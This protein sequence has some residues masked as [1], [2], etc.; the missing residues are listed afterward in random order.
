[1]QTLS[2]TPGRALLE[3]S[4]T[5]R[6][7][8][9]RFEDEGIAAYLYVCDRALGHGDASILD[10]M[11]IYNV[12]ALRQAAQS[13]RSQLSD[14]QLS[15]LQLGDSQSSDSQLSESQLTK[16]QPSNAEPSAAQI[17]APPTTSSA[18]SAAQTNTSEPS[19][20]ER[21]AA[22][23]WSRDGLQAVFYLDGT[24]QAM[25]DFTRRISFC[26]SDFPNFLAEGTE[27][28]RSSTHAWDPAA[29]EHFEA[30]LYA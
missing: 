24:A 23:E 9:L 29:V 5:N 16:S 20:P 18:P 12:A 27:R 10:A 28:W 21:L 22:I 25:A 6:T 4:P 15:D 3:S 17:N 1:M 8:S 30:T 7:W 11:L 26:R 2:F 19:E 13:S 14:L